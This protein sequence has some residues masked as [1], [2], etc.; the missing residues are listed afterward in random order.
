[1]L[2]LPIM[3]FNKALALSAMA[4]VAIGLSAAQPASAQDF[5][6]EDGCAARVVS[7][8]SGDALRVYN[9]SRQKDCQQ[10][11]NARG[12]AIFEAGCFNVQPSPPKQPAGA[13]RNQPRQQQ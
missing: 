11:A 2:N 3:S 12:T 9:C 4:T 6:W 7:P 5:G 1:M 13:V 8:G 10:I